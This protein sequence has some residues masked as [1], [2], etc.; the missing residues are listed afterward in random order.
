MRGDCLA[1]LAV[2]GFG[3]S[4]GERELGL[5]VPTCQLGCGGEK[6]R[7]VLHGIVARRQQQRDGVI[8]DPELGPAAPG[9]RVGAKALGVETV[10]DHDPAPWP[11]SNPGTASPLPKLCV[12]LNAIIGQRGGR[13]HARLSDLVPQISQQIVAQEP[14]TRATKSPPLI[15]TD[16]LTPDRQ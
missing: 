8:G 6:I 13:M 14:V 7:V 3:A 5:R 16:A 11:P 15:D 1:Q 12:T 2:P 10:R 9:P 4:P